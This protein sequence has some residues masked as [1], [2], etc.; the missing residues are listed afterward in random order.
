MMDARLVQFDR[1]EG[2]TMTLAVAATILIVSYCRDFN[3][4]EC[5]RTLVKVPMYCD[6]QADL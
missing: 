2:A 5:G 1:S 3:P 6:A 4:Q